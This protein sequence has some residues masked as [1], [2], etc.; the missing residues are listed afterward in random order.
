MERSVAVIF[1]MTELIGYR[2]YD[3]AMKRAN[4]YKR[5]LEEVFGFDVVEI[6][7]NNSRA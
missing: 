7:I 4:M 2:E 1:V 5:W 3:N 6:N